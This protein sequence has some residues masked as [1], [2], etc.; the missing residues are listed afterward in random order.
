MSTWPL[1]LI[2][3]LY[4]FLQMLWWLSLTCPRCSAQTTKQLWFCSS[5]E[6][7]AS[8]TRAFSSTSWKLVSCQTS[9][10]PSGLTRWAVKTHVSSPLTPWLHIDPSCFVSPMK[11]SYF[12]A[13]R[14]WASQ[15][16]TSLWLLNSPFK[17]EYIFILHV[18]YKETLFTWLWY[19]FLL[20]S[21]SCQVSTQVI[22]LCASVTSFSTVAGWSGIH[23]HGSGPQQILVYSC[24]PPA[25]QVLRSFLWIRG[26]NCAG[27]FSHPSRLQPLQSS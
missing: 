7:T 24:S 27:G 2:S 1:Y 15:L 25:H 16:I 14:S 5:T 12:S 10:Q 26:P 6:F 23:R 21:S 11:N 20:P 4:L 8:R 9:R 18:L 22:R 3:I 13:L 19:F 17:H